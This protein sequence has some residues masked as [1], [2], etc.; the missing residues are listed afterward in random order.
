MAFSRPGAPAPTMSASVS[1]SAAPATGTAARMTA[2]QQRAAQ[3]GALQAASPA[4]PVEITSADGQH[5]TVSFS[6]VRNFICQK[7]TDAECK[8]FLET[9]K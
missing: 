4:K 8:I 5:M 3:S 7:A 6:D 1:S 2:M 9:C